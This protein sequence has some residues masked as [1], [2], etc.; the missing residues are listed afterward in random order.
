MPYIPTI[1]DWV[2]VIVAEARPW[3]GATVLFFTL[4]LTRFSGA[5]DDKAKYQ[6][7]KIKAA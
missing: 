4:L 2:P 5:L 3:I 1:N 6:A 7:V